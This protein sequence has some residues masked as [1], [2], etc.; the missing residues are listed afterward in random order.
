MGT[1]NDIF[2][3]MSKCLISSLCRNDKVIG[4]HSASNRPGD[5]TLK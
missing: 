4:R 1:H 3:E 5:I 2:N